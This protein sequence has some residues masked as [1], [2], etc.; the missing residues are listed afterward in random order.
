METNTKALYE[1]PVTEVIDIKF[2]G[3]VCDGSPQS[4]NQT[5]DYVYYGGL[6]ES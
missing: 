5:R 4:N 2:E 3:I 6:D 1:T